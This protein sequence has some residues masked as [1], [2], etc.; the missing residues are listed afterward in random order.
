MLKQLLRVMTNTVDASEPST[1]DIVHATNLSTCESRYC[2]AGI[3]AASTARRPRHGR[4]I[5]AGVLVVLVLS[6]S[7]GGHQL[8]QRS[9]MYLLSSSAQ[10]ALYNLAAADS[11]KEP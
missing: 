5:A 10:S 7:L 2:S 8:A 3:P 1:S 11:A 6:W 9:A 4:C